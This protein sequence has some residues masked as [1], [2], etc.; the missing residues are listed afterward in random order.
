MNK[1][2]RN[3]GTCWSL[4]FKHGVKHKHTTALVVCG[5]EKCSLCP[6]VYL[7]VICTNLLGVLLNDLQLQSDTTVMAVRKGVIYKVK[8]TPL[9]FFYIDNLILH[10]DAFLVRS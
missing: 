5:D 3:E 7:I 8:I 6:G 9:V 4:V 10:R 2:K 1:G